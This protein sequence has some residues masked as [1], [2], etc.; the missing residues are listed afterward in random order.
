MDENQ[1]RRR[2]LS[3]GIR[4]LLWAMALCGALLGWWLEYRYDRE[5]EKIISEAMEYMEWT[6]SL[7]GPVSP[8]G[9][10]RGKIKYVNGTEVEWERLPEERQ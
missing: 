4:D 9:V 6:E 1:P 3:F 10:V 5:R 2:W 7:E 8:L